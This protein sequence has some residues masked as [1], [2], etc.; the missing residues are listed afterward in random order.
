MLTGPWCRCNAAHNEPLRRADG[1]THYPAASSGDTANAPRRSTTCLRWRSRHRGS[2]TASVQ[3]CCTYRTMGEALKSQAQFFCATRPRRGRRAAGPARWRRGD[4]DRCA[5]SRQASAP[6]APETACPPQSRPI[7]TPAACARPVT[8]PRR[9][10]GAGLDLCKPRKPEPGHQGKETQ[11]RE[12]I[13]GGRAVREQRM[14]Q[15]ER[16]EERQPLA[17]DVERPVAIERPVARLTRPLRLQAKVLGR[18]IGF[19]LLG[20][21]SPFKILNVGPEDVTR[22]TPAA[23]PVGSTRTK[24]GQSAAVRPSRSARACMPAM[25]RAV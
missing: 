14:V 6:G 15:S 2:V 25:T 4:A 24:R 8:A 11:P 21:Y 13:Y 7:G 9:G 22:R 16:L 1:R 3:L 12:G 5:R 17:L 18:I 10:R 23:Q 20:T 19:L